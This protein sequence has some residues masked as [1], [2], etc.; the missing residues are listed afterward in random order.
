MRLIELSDHPGG[1]LRDIQR[2]RRADDGRVHEQY[3]TALA[4]HKAR[5]DQ[6]RARR[7]E[8]RARHRWFGW[9]RG[10]V[11]VWA[12]QRR[13]PRPSASVSAPTARE[14]SIAAGMAGERRIATELGHVLGDEWLL[15]RGYRNSRG[16][17]DH[18][19]LGPRGLFAIEVKYHNATVYVS[20]DDWRFEKFDRWGNRVEQGRIA[21]RTGRSPSA[22]LNQPADELERFLES[23]G[24]PVSITR[25]VILNHPR[26]RVGGHKNLTVKVATSSQ[27]IVDLVRESQVDLQGSRRSQL[28]RLI[29]QDHRFHNRRRPPR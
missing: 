1:M 24:Q 8:A 21:D 16:E 22:Q 9:I 7:D 12:E 6:A 15:F 17:I 5:L 29:E 10:I 20:G 18:L 25:V 13:L 2:Q 14:E 23:R 28:A 3:A 26:S 11:A 4:Q 19:L 27:Y